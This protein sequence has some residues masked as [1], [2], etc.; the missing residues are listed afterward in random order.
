[1]DNGIVKVVFCILQCCMWCFEKC[2]KFINKNAYI[3]VAL[4]GKSFC[5]AAFNAFTLI[6]SNLGR[7][8]MW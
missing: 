2:M 1:M 5:G 6:I 8:G 7:V 3:I 4:K